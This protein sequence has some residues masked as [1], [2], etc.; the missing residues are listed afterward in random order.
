MLINLIV[1]A[2]DAM[3]NMDRP[4]ILTLRTRLTSSDMIQIE[5]EDNGSGIEGSDLHR[6]FDPFFTTKTVGEGI[7]MGLS[8]GHRIIENHG[9]TISVNSTHGV[10]TVFVVILPRRDESG[11]APRANT[12][13]LDSMA[14]GS[15]AGE[16]L[17]PS[18]KDAD[19]SGR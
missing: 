8:I 5:V 17:I 11:P 1:N 18:A 19:A 16:A 9:G 14:P 7:G 12:G 3:A 4:A 13:P 2:A 15:A 6:V 10:G